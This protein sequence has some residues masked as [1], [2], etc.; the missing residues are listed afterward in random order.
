MIVTVFI[1]FFYKQ[2]SRNN[3]NNINNII[4]TTIMETYNITEY[5]ILKEKTKGLASKYPIGKQF[6]EYIDNCDFL[7]N[8]K[9]N[10]NDKIFSKELTR[11]IL[12]IIKNDTMIMLEK[13]ND[14]K[15]Y[16]DIGDLYSLWKIIY[17]KCFNPIIIIGSGV[18]GLTIASGIKTHN[19]LILEARERI[20]GRVFTNDN[21]LDMGAAWIHG[22]N[23]DNPLNKF[24]NIDNLIPVSSCNPWMHSENTK[25]KYMNKTH[26]ITEEMRQKLASKWNS[27]ATKIGGIQNK[28]IIEGFEEY[29]NEEDKD[30]LF[31]FLYM[32]EVWCGGSIKNIS[33]SFLHIC[34]SKT[35]TKLA[36]LSDKGNSFCE[37]LHALEK[38]E[39]VNEN[40]YTNALFGDYGGSHCLFKNGAKTLIDAIIN[41]F[42]DKSQFY[43]KI[44]YNQIVTKVIYND[45]YV[46]VHT[47]E[48][49]IYNCNKL[50]ITAPPGP[51][52][53]IEFL[54]PLKSERIDSL[55]KI[56]MGSYKKIQIEFNDEDI[57]W[58][59]IDSPMFL[60]CNSKIDG[61][62]YYLHDES[63]EFPYILWNNYKYS[64]NKPILEAICPANIGWKL[65]GINDEIIIDTMTTQLRNYYP[66]MPE[67]K[68]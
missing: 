43:E 67:P 22:S 56:K 35:P 59:D 36:E 68:A 12:L 17:I 54:P 31:S 26:N 46:E 63:S 27:I 16:S 10:I 66:D 23:Q 65:R 1:Q 32:I 45:Y 15:K 49:K 41:S 64:K 19:F 57:F 61:E 60:T 28:T 62:Q 40:N 5:D 48:G 21:N 30:D 29:N 34:T 38:C 44:R 52:K 39:G 51:L 18:S 25:I 58:N 53:D 6:I 33:T 11:E 8:I 47:N 50:C 4:L 42:D 20:G 24:I 9:I 14:F 3:I 37:S 2:F 13:I 55:S 7:T